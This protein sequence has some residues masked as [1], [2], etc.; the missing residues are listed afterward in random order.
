MI[1]R[2]PIEPLTLVV[3]PQEAMV[4]KYAHEAGADIDLVLRSANDSGQTLDT[5]M[6]TLQYIFDLYN[7]EL[8][9]RLPYGVTPL[10]LDEVQ[11]AGGGE[12]VQ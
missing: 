7:M 3:S 8:P 4:L 11:T 9:P 1:E 6:V 5:D 2:A 10:D 12:R